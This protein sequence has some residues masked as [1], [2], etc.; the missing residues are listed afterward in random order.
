MCLFKAGSLHCLSIW[1]QGAAVAAPAFISSPA[2]LLTPVPLPTRPPTHLQTA[3]LD[4]LK[5]LPNYNTS[6]ENWKP[7][8]YLSQGVQAQLEALL[9]TQVGA[10][11]NGTAN[12]FGYTCPSP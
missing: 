6:S 5:T 12:P 10:C 2:C 1:V 7:M 8:L 4:M 9:G 3:V 11:G